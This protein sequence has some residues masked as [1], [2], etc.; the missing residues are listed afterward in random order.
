MWIW[1]ATGY[2]PAPFPRLDEPL[3]HGWDF[4]VVPLFVLLGVR[5]PGV[6]SQWAISPSPFSGAILFLRSTGAWPGTC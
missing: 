2:E 1:L 3:D 6:C 4:A 5:M